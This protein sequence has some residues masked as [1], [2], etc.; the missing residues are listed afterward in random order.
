MIYVITEESLKNPIQGRTSFMPDTV[1]SCHSITSLPYLPR[2]GD[3]LRIRDEYD[4]FDTYPQYREVTGVLHD[5][6]DE[7]ADVYLVVKEYI[8]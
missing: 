2:V 1:T 6:R 3:V 4:G 7:D 5:I 8:V